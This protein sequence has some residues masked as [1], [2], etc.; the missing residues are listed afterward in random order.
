VRGDNV[1][2]F[3]AANRSSS[4]CHGNLLRANYG[5]NAVSEE[6][7]SG[8]FAL[9]L[10]PMS[11]S[12]P[13]ARRRQAADF[14]RTHDADTIYLVG[15]IVDGWALKSSWHW[16]HRTMI[17]CRDAAESAE[18]GPRS[19]TSPQSRRVPAQLLRHAFRRHRRGENAV[20]YRLRRQALSRHSRHIFDLVVQNAAG[21]PISATKG[22]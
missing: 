7:R 6:S 11:I 9:C 14:L 19:S 17:S 20:H 21:S 18:K 4:P 3:R 22:L 16:P 1:K 13:A 5:S 15:D 2:R 8:A 12:E 10:S